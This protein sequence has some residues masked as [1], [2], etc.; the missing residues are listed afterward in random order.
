M[1]RAEAE[2]QHKG[3]SEGVGGAAWPTAWLLWV[4]AGSRRA[5]PGEEP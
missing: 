5:G 3:G 4:E 2:G 1:L